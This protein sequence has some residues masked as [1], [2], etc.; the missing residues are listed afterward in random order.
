MPGTTAPATGS[1]R[2]S[3]GC[4]QRERAGLRR[5]QGVSTGTVGKMPRR[6]T[7]SKPARRAE[8]QVLAE[9]AVARVLQR[10]RRANQAPGQQEV[11]A[12]LQVREVRHR[13]QQL[14]AGR[15]HAEQLGERLRLILVRQVLEHV[16]AQRAI[17]AAGRR[18]ER[19]QRSTPDV[20]RA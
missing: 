4:S 2:V 5:I 16:E 17:E 19:Q 10:V 11:H 7:T 13:D 1:S 14:A 15:Q 20:R 6:Q 18:R 8:R 12:R 3:A 9:R